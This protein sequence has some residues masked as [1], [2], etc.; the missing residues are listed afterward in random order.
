MVPISV[1]QCVSDIW[2]I[3][4]Q[5]TIPN[6]LFFNFQLQCRLVLKLL[7]DDAETVKFLNHDKLVG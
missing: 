3:R 2:V 1:T 7:F 6:F 4:I 5:Y